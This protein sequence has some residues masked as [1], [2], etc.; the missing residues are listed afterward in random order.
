MGKSRKYT[1]NEFIEAVTE[2]FSFAQVLSKVGLKPAGGNYV[3]AKKKVNDLY[4]DIS[5]YR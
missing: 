3:S 2:S 1:D 5:H 4:L